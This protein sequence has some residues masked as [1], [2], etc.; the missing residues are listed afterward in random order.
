MN[1][2]PLV[3]IA[4]RESG[5]HSAQCGCGGRLTLDKCLKEGS[6]KTDATF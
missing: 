6:R 3:L 2:T 1:S 4:N 5:F